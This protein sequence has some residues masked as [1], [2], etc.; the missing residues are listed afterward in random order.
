MPGRRLCGRKA[1][2]GYFCITQLGPAYQGRYTLAK[3][4]VQLCDGGGLE[5][6]YFNMTIPRNHLSVLMYNIR[7]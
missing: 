4:A 3:T 1:H 2:N 5:C 7:A 6:S